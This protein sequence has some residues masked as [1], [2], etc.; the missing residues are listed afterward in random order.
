MRHV[1]VF[2]VRVAIF[3][4]VFCVKLFV[5]THY[6]L[7]Y[8]VDTQVLV[9]SMQICIVFAAVNL[10]RTSLFVISTIHDGRHYATVEEEEEDECGNS[11]LEDGVAPDTSDDAAPAP[12]EGQIDTIVFAGSRSLRE[13]V[14][15][16]HTI[17]LL[18]WGTFYS[19]DFS[20][21]MT[22][23]W[24]VYGLLLGWLVRIW[25]AGPEINIVLCVVYIGLFATVLSVNRPQWSSLVDADTL[26]F[27]VIFPVAFGVGWMNCIHDSAIL[28][29]AE[30]ALVTCVLVCCLVMSTSEWTPLFALL[31]RERA[32]FVYV[33]VVEPVAKSLALYVFVLSLLTR[34]HQQIL[35]VFVCTY[36]LASILSSQST[37]PV[38]LTTTVT[39]VCV[40]FVLQGLR[41]CRKATTTVV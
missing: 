6:D 4:A 1:L 41:V 34:H 18:L 24:F 11:S 12:S 19:F 35:F 16:M 33:L 38:A 40:L 32:L 28:D 30:N 29:N 36:A 15:C 21:T 5:R 9:S 3:Q 26:F 7:H 13:Y 25:R 22:F 10:Y 14:L 37:E 23:Y 27:A 8:A 39:A 20:T 31:A 2:V 17:G